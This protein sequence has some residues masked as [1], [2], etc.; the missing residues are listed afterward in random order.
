MQKKLT[1]AACA[2]A[3]IVIARPAIAYDFTIGPINASTTTSITAGLG[4][5]TKNPSCSLTGDPTTSCGEG[6]NTAQYSNGDDGDLNYHKGQPYTASLGVVSEGLFTLRDAGVKVFVRGSGTYDFAAGHTQRTDLSASATS[7]TVWQ[8]QLLDLWAQKDFSVAGNSAHVRVG[9]QVINWGESIFASGGINVTNSYDIQKL[10]TPGSQLKQALLPAPMVSFAS[11]LGRGFSTEG[12]YQFGWN[13]NRFPAVGT[14]WSVSDVLGRGQQS[15]SLSTNNL[16]VGGRDPASIGRATGNANLAGISSGLLTGDYAGPPFSSIGVP[17]S[18]SLPSGNNQFGMRFNWSPSNTQLNLSAY[19]IMYTDKTPVGTARPDG[20]VDFSYLKNRQMFGLSANMPV[21]DWAVGWETSYRPRDA[22]ALSGCY[23]EGG[24]T[25]ANT[26]LATGISCPLYEDKK[27]LQMTLN[28]LLALTKSQYPFLRWIGADSAA[29]TAEASWI[30][31]PG[32][33]SNTQVH[34]TIGGQS[35]YQVPDA[36]YATWLQNG[37]QGYP[38]A[39]AQG[40][41]SSLGITLDFNWTYDGTLVKGWQVTPGVTFTDSVYGYT[42]NLSANYASGAKSLNLYVL[43]T[44][45]PAKWSAGINFAAYFGGNAL[46]QPYG[47]RNYVAAFVTRT[48]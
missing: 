46:S 27:R 4:I 18:T 37:A 31:Y 42:P 38:I 17:Y 44:Q 39:A 30:Y 40:T 36:A 1:S 34:R 21:G 15:G 8:L 3:A 23:G 32:V 28:G 14:Y 19:Y 22:V 47:D 5:R 35:V 16:N 6:A 29:L 48:F 24:A 2:A 45:N 41:A 25:D 11:D 20:S 43:F 9:N 13:S 7:Q 12:Y 26:N 10:L 33:S